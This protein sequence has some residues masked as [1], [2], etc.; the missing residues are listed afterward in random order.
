[1]Q[2]S[3]AAV[4][5]RLVHEAGEGNALEVRRLMFKE[6]E[7]RG[8]Q[9]MTTWQIAYEHPVKCKDAEDVRARL[10]EWLSYAIECETSKGY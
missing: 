10:A 3:I 6:W 4:T 9:V 7:S 5:R 2:I 8:P 1:M